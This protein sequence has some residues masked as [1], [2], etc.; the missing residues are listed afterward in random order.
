MFG[1]PVGLVA[2]PRQKSRASDMERARCPFAAAATDSRAK[3][4]AHGG[5]RLRAGGVLR[6][7]ALLQI[8]FEKWFC[9]SVAC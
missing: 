3:R 7:S 9:S 4:A 1:L 6:S 8:P 5:D 2:E